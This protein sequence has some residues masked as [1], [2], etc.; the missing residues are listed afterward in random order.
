[1]ISN[2]PVIIALPLYGNAAAVGAKDAEIATDADCAQLAVP[3][4]EPLCV[5]INDPVKEP[6]NGA[7]K[8][9][10]CVELEI[11]PTC[12]GAKDAEIATDADCAQL[13]VPVRVPINDP[14]NDPVLICAELLTIP[15]GNPVGNIYDDVVATLLVPNNDPVIPPEFI[16]NDPVINTLPLISKSVV[17]FALSIPIRLPVTT[18]VFLLNDPITT[19]SSLKTSSMGNPEISLTL[20]N[21]PDKLS[22]IPNSDPE[23]P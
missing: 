13:P 18:R 4:V 12:I 7:V 15:V 6:V 1:V 20:I 5:P 2:D 8:D 22:V 3:N 17:G 11:T 23:L 19:L 10:N 21:D 14:V 16:C 9:V